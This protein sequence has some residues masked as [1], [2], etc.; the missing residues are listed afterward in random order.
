MTERNVSTET[1]KLNTLLY[2]R[3]YENQSDTTI[4]VL[5]ETMIKMIEELGKTI[6]TTIEEIEEM[7]MTKTIEEIEEAIMM[8]I[9]T[10]EV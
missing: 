6:M 1:E 5:A 2:L 4:R 3:V 9:E 8:T 7:M 10:I